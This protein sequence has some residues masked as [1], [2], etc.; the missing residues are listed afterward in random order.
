MAV[1]EEWLQQKYVEY[2]DETEK[3]NTKVE[4]L[5]DKI[6]NLLLTNSLTKKYVIYG[7][8]AYYL[9]NKTS[10]PEEIQSQLSGGNSTEVADFT[11][12]IDVYGITTDLKVYYCSSGLDNTVY[13]S[14]E[15][16][17]IDANTSASLINNSSNSSLNSTIVS[18]LEE[19]GIEVDPELRNY[20]WKFVNS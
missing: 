17:L 10:L 9:L 1:L 12:L 15:G 6:P 8:K 5:T 13:G 16:A 14:A 7:G 2:Y 4:L 11:K 18:A 3:F 20:N 19:L